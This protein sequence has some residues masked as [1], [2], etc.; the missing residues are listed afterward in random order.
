MHRLVA[1]KQ[2]RRIARGLYDKP[3]ENR[4]TGKLAY[5]NPR[6]IIDARTRRGKVQIVVDGITAASDLGLTDAVPA[7]VGV[8]TDG[9]PR[10]VV[11]GNLTIDFQHA[12]PSR[13]YWSGH[14]AMRFVQALYWLRDRLPSD[15]GTLHKRLLSILTDPTHGQ[16][17]QTDLKDGLSA[18]PEWMREIVRDLLRQVND[19]MP[20]AAEKSEAAASPAA[21]KKG[22]KTTAKRGKAS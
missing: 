21:R 16:A 4:L 11:F 14:P 10:P 19:E 12:S 5:P 18:L 17:I 9:R 15:D 3:Q 1:S 13:L 7:R 2:L 20:H 22:N 6:E 8:L